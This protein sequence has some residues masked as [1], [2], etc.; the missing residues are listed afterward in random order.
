V[1]V[2]VGVTALLAVSIAAQNGTSSTGVPPV[3]FTPESSST[4]VPP[5]TSTPESSAAG[6]PPVV[7][8]PVSSDVSS[9][10]TIPH[11]RDGHATRHVEVI[12]LGDGVKI[13]M[14]Y[15][16]GGSF[17]MGSPS[18]ESGRDADE[19][20]VHTVELDGFWIGKFEVTNAQYRRFKSDHNSGS[21]GGYG[22][23]EDSQPVVKVSWNDA[24]AF[25]EW[26]SGRTGKTFRLP[27][28]AEWEYA[29]RAGTRT[30]R[31][32]GNSDASL[33]AY[34]NVFNPSIKRENDLDWDSFTWEDRHKVA[35]PTGSFKPN[36]WGLYDIIGNAKEW[37]EDWYG[38]Y[39]SASAKNPKGAS[40][41]EYRVLRGGSWVHSP[42]DCRSANRDW[43]DPKDIINPYGFRLAGD[44]LG[45]L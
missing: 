18:S 13:E 42:G 23:N 11:G 20:P 8:T 31:F 37:C 17:E 5:V 21:F 43:S 26:L 41:G 7:S 38:P 35:S 22:V 30:A 32:P 24:K 2:L 33:E 39:L 10:A 9:S 36:P 40:L 25:C 29:C 6:V 45:G 16:E 15:I 19:G 14:V 44:F 12:D 4:G 27:T 34:A 1:F 3:V 28:E